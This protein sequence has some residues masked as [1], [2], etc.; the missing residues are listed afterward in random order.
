[1]FSKNKITIKQHGSGY[2]HDNETN[3]LAWHWFL[4][5]VVC[6][7]QSMMIHFVH[8]NVIPLMLRIKLTA[9]HMPWETK[10]VSTSIEANGNSTG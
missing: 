4:F 8:I 5:V 10:Q 3:G 2:K 1:M 7:M 9:R 6:N